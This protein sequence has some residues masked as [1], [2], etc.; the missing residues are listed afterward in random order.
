MR[1]WSL[2]SCGQQQLLQAVAQSPL[3]AKVTAVDV[4]SARGLLLAGDQLG[5]VLLFGWQQ[6]GQQVRGGLVKDCL[7]IP[8]NHACCVSVV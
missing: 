1:C 4:C 5:N 3:K 6:Q 8:V 7:L 2:G